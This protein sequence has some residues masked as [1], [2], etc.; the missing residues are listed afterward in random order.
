MIVAVDH[1]TAFTASQQGE[2][3]GAMFAPHAGEE[4]NRAYDRSDGAMIN[5]EL[6]ERMHR[7]VEQG[8]CPRQYLTCS[9]D[10]AELHTWREGS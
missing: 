9:G 8:M 4:E 5:D 2:V 1:E 3:R 6:R 7:N 10:E